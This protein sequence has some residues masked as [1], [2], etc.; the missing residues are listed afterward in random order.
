MKKLYILASLAVGALTFTSCEADKEPVYYA[1]DPATF[2]L[3]TPPLANQLYVLENGGEVELT[4]SQP[5][6]GIATVTNYSVDVTLADDFIEATED[7]EANYVTITPTQPTQAKIMLDAKT[8]DKTICEMMGIKTYAK[9]PEE[10]IA[11]VKLTMRAHAWITDVSSSLCVSNNIVLDAV[12]LYNPFSPLPGHI[13]YVGSPSWVE[14]SEANAVF[15]EEWSFEETGVGTNLY[16]GSVNI[17]AGKQWFRLYTELE[18]WG[19]TS[20]GPATNEAVVNITSTAITLPEITFTQDNWT[21]PETW[22]GGDV[23]F[24]IN[25]T[26]SENPVI[27][28]KEGK[29]V[30]ESYVYLVGSM[31]G[32]AEPSE[33]SQSVYDNWRLIDNSGSGIYS[34][35]FDI[36]AGDLYFRVYPELTGWGATPYASDNGGADLTMTLGDAYKCATGEGCW[37]FNWTGGK[38]TF[39]LDTTSDPATL[40]VTPATE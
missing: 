31:A 29:Y 38:I 18:G 28:V 11:P 23:T 8:L 17:P 9:Y 25:L 1:P 26:D 5:D 27:T 32:W 4:T 36:A 16:I 12:Q 22:A 30:K 34:N 21:T 37:T 35:T 19:G 3:N 20:Y 10:G 40:T 15:Y 13:Y 33:A 6:Y 14:P 2:V 7:T 24:E 39:T